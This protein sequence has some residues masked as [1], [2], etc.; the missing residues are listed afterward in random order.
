M[1]EFAHSWTID[2]H[3]S[4]LLG[5]AGTLAALGMLLS[6]VPVFRQILRK[7]DTGAV[8]GLPY[9]LTLAQCSLWTMYCSWTPGRAAPLLTNAFGVL[10]EAVYV[11]LFLLYARGDVR[12]AFAR[13]CA[14]V[15]FLVLVFV[16][17]VLTAVAQPKRAGVTGCAVVRSSEGQTGKG[18]STPPRFPPFTHAAGA[19]W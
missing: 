8:P 6:P 7:R 12:S 10:C 2:P 5:V 18:A 19:G 9:L 14:G 1:P 11:A 17:W 13:L 4:D 15:A 16:V 3:V